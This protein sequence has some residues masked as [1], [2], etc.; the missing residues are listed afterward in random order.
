MQRQ[1][2]QQQRNNFANVS[3]ALI[4]RHFKNILVVNHPKHL[5]NFFQNQ[6]F[7]QMIKI[8]LKLQFLPKRVKRSVGL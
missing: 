8:C 1:I 7:L 3:A 2:M 6:S 4:L 5:K